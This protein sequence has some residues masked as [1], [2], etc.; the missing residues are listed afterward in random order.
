M[1]RK[2][3]VKGKI[4]SFFSPIM[5]EQWG[6]EIEACDG[7]H[8]NLELLEKVR[9]IT[10]ADEFRR[11]KNDR[12][13]YLIPDAS[14]VTIPGIKQDVPRGFVHPDIIL[15]A[16]IMAYSRIVEHGLNE[17]DLELVYKHHCIEPVLFVG[18]T[19]G[20]TSQESLTIL[21]YYIGRIASWV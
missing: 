18:K 3:I 10:M 2:E 20:L 12:G 6:R 16:E 9:K 21:N 11:L 13:D 17:G 4:T 1:N 5:L 19:Y 15:R 8:E 7:K 14:E